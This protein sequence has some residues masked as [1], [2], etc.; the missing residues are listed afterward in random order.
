M[1]RN[2]RGFVLVSV[3]WVVAL[4]TV[5]TI[6]YHHRAR[7]EVRAARY[8]LDAAQA[9]VAARGAV[10]RGVLE[11]RN[12]TVLE[13]I[14][15][16]PGQPTHGPITHL[17]QPWA[18]V[19]NLLGDGA[20]LDPGEGFEN[21]VVQYAI[22]DLERYINI[23]GASEDVIAAL[24]GMSS[25]VARRIHYIRTGGGADR[26]FQHLSELRAIR[27]VDDGGWFGDGDSPG[28]RD[29]LTVHGDGRININ[30]AP[31]AVLQHLPDVDPAAMAD[32]VAL[33]QGEDG[34][35]GTADDRGV[36]SWEQFAEIS[37]IRGGTL[38]ALQRFCKFNS[39]YFKISAVATRRG[40]MI[41]SQCSAIVTVPS[42]TDIASLLS[43]SEESLG[44]P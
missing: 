23:N 36:S 7:L 39:N 19:G 2:R 1:N 43:W 16:V 21:D 41:R 4:L 10:E 28:L 8:N 22:E 38:V 32:W 13:S 14:V 31:L 27:G 37:G 33:R 5:I 12:K 15:Q 40:G 30:T 3:L 29:V 35:A 34:L 42:G 26:P 11:L 20:L 25:P 17:G 9:R 18:Q 6:S 44:S 24:P